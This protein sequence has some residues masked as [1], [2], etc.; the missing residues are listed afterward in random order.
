[1]AFLLVEPVFVGPDKSILLQA[2]VFS[3]LT[4]A[5]VS[6][7][8]F[9]VL[10]LKWLLAEGVTHKGNR[11]TTVFPAMCMCTSFLV[12]LPDKDEV[13][14]VRGDLITLC[15]YLKGGGRQGEVS[16]SSPR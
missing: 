9:M 6:Q 14:R 16:V 8:D 13:R 4:A 11:Y 5:T 10:I 15:N 1:M 7:A 12:S 3:R 2:V